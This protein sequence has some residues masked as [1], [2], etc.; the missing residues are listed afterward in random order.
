[1]PGPNSSLLELDQPMRFDFNLNVQDRQVPYQ[2]T[3]TY[4]RDPQ[5]EEGINAEVVCA[6][7]EDLGPKSKAKDFHVSLPIPSFGRNAL[8]LQMDLGEFPV[9]NSG[10]RKEIS[11]AMRGNRMKKE[12][13]V[14]LCPF[15]SVP[16]IP[17]NGLSTQAVREIIRQQEVLA[18]K[19]YGSMN[20]NER[21]DSRHCLGIAQRLRLSL[22][23]TGGQIFDS[24]FEQEF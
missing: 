4:R 7:R 5:N 18:R 15:Q 22:D 8:I 24:G 21:E 9:E 16:K 2:I 10:Q 3:V 14:V 19:F 12:A 13:V 6:P 17:K 20:P 23:E 1:M 11:Y